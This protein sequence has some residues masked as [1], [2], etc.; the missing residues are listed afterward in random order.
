MCYR[1]L[2][3]KL[4][5]MEK[6]RVTKARYSRTEK[7][8][9]VHLASN[10]R[11][12]QTNKGKAAGT[13]FQRDRR[14]RVIAALGGK[15]ARCGFEDWRALQIDHMNGGGRRELKQI[16]YK[17]IIKKVLRGETD[18]YQL[19]CSNCNWIKRYEKNE[20]IGRSTGEQL[21]GGQLPLQA[22]EISPR[23]L[24]LAQM[25]GSASSAFYRG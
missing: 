25:P 16:G 4:E 17:G 22:N 5:D 7:G 18:G 23:Q 9:A 1:K 2:E 24:S 10:H 13:R 3:K 14:Q 8:R 12:C 11:Y 19:L 15:C 21:Q 6:Q 20:H